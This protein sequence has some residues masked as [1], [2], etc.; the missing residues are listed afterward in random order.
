MGRATSLPTRK[1][2][3]HTQAKTREN[4]TQAELNS[5]TASR[6]RENKRKGGPEQQAA[7][8]NAK[9]KRVSEGE[10]ERQLSNGAKPYEEVKEHQAPEGGRG[11]Q[12]PHQAKPARKNTTPTPKTEPDQPEN[13][14]P[15]RQPQPG[16]GSKNRNGSQTR[17]GRDQRTRR[18]FAFL[19]Y[20]ANQGQ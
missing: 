9:K 10:P 16:A 7:P 17:Q 11:S 8:H 14:K 15:T 13:P 18:V 2:L 6:K 19:P 5:K 1:S 12:T 20:F 3:H 4:A